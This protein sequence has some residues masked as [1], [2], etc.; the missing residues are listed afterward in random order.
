MENTDRNKTL[1]KSASVT[2][3]YARHKLGERGKKMT[4]SQINDL[5]TTLRVLCN[6][7]IDSVVQ[8]YD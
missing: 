4:D 6:K 7:T 1:N 8:K 2:I 5:I 3:E